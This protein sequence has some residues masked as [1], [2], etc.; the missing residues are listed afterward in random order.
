MTLGKWKPVLFLS[1]F[2]L[3]GT[4]LE[5]Q[6]SSN[7]IYS[8]W[9]PAVVYARG[10]SSTT[11]EV[12]TTSGVR[13]VTLLFGSGSSADRWPLY[14]DGTHGDKRAGDLVFTSSGILYDLGPSGTLGISDYVANLEL[15][16]SSGATE[17]ASPA[18][19]GIIE[20]KAEQHWTPVLARTNVWVT[21]YG[22]FIKDD[23]KIFPGFPNCGTT[24]GR[25]NTEPFRRLYEIFPDEFDFATVMPSKDL[26]DPAK[27]CNPSPYSTRVKN[28]VEHI[29]LD[30][31]DLT[32]AFYS[33]GRLK[34]TIFHS[35]GIPQILDHEMGHAWG[36]N[37]GKSLGLSDDESHWVAYQAPYC[38][39]SSFP[40]LEIIAQNSDG[41]YKVE[42]HDFG[43]EN[44][45]YSDIMLYSMGLMD[46]SEVKP[47]YHLKKTNQKDWNRVR[48]SD[49]DIYTIDQI[50]Q[51]AG[52][53]RIPSYPQA[54]RKFTMAFIFVS[55][56]DFSPAEFDYFSRLAKWFGSADPD[57]YNGQTFRNATGGRGTMTTRLPLEKLKAPPDRSR[58][59]RPKPSGEPEE[60]K[61][62]VTTGDRRSGSGSGTSSTQAEGPPPK[63]ER[64]ERPSGSAS[65]DLHIQGMGVKTAGSQGTTYVTETVGGKTRQSLAFLPGG[66]AHCSATVENEGG[67]RAAGCTIVK[68][69][70]PSGWVVGYNPFD[71]APQ[72][73]KFVDL[74]VNISKTAPAG[75]Y[76][77]KLKAQHKDDHTPD[78]NLIVLHIT[79]VRQ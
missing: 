20:Q 53:N 46:K 7:Y 72:E 39:M 49:F 30:P 60:P 64:G 78:N 51:A 35:F 45:P 66:I 71:L 16:L 2:F 17:T 12:F 61:G 28:E 77:V 74:Y 41:T 18:L 22:V 13:S 8:V 23:G 10:G 57:Y 5:A 50:I 79:V 43:S 3:A 24:I 34:M 38:Q 69:D 26:H 33:Q 21:D 73:K 32:Q 4:G 36:A 55:N 63:D 76:T 6:D 58:P 67:D 25:G 31:L 70:L 19:L 27:K 40:A 52:G 68:E 62:T 65:V 11:L 42:K 14:D 47:F 44:R 29:G 54:A 15:V 75:E 48:M 1:A 37:L 9:H 56:E 59:A